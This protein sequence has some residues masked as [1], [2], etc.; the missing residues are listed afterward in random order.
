MMNENS[1]LT[2]VERLRKR[3]FPYSI[4]APSK[5][6]AD[7]QRTTLR[8]LGSLVLLLV[9]MLGLV[10]FRFAILMTQGELHL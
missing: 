5:R 7:G 3:R 4:H 10:A 1:T 9:I 2:W 6:K 8:L